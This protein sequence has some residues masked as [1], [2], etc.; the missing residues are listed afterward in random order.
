[1]PS[2]ARTIP[3]GELPFSVVGVAPPTL[4]HVC[5]Q[6]HAHSSTASST[7][8]A[9]SYTIRRHR[10]AFA[11]VPHACTRLCS[12]T[13]LV[14]PSANCSLVTGTADSRRA[15]RLL[16]VLNTGTTHGAQPATSAPLRREVR[17]DI[18]PCLHPSAPRCVTFWSLSRQRGFLSDMC[19][20]IL[21]CADKPDG[22]PVR[23][24][25]QIYDDGSLRGAFCVLVIVM[26]GVRT[27]REMSRLL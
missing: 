24:G 4:P 15:S 14:H 22:R 21:L 18:H 9:T 6:D 10:H 20:L 16:T 19:W 11:R 1:M 23:A 3:L 13:L 27:D 26:N 25:T 12:A 5:A 2:N 8:R 7:A 17:R